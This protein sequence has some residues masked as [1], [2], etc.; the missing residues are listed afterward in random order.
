MKNKIMSLLTILCI[1]FSSALYAAPP[2][3]YNKVKRNTCLAGYSGCATVPVTLT[4]SNTGSGI[5]RVIDH[6]D[7]GEN[8]SAYNNIIK[9][10]IS[11]HSSS[12]TYYLPTAIGDEV[13][14]PATDGLTFG[15]H[16]YTVSIRKT[17]AKE[18]V[19]A[20]SDLVL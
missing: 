14:I 10:T 7:A 19:L 16:G 17:A 3:S 4:L 11:G 20:V 15:G 8:F 6:P 18:F 9:V 13:V 1:A 12:E 2:A 5:S